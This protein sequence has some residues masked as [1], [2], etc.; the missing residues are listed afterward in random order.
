[1]KKKS[2]GPRVVV[3]TPGQ[4]KPLSPHEKHEE[5]RKIVHVL[6]NQ[7]QV[8]LSSLEMG[9]VKQAQDYVRQMVESL[10]KLAKLLAQAPKI[11]VH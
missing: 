8:I 4:V 6:N 10:R 2:T 11:K 7:T 9:N 5:T 1:M 3:P